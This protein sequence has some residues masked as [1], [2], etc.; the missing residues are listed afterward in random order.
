METKTRKPRRKRIKIELGKNYPINDQF[1]RF[2]KCS[3]LSE[4]GKEL[5][6]AIFQKENPNG[7]CMTLLA[8]D[9]GTSK[10]ITYRMDKY[11]NTLIS[12][13]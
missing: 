13:P 2:E 12:L 9:E 5:Y 10:V 4:N 1:I 6:R 3:Y 8:I 11:Y 7:C